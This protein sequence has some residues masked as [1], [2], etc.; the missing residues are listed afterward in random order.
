MFFICL[1][2]S[3]ARLEL[4]L[5]ILSFLFLSSYAQYT[6]SLET[7]DSS[8][9]LKILQAQF[10]VLDSVH[11]TVQASARLNANKQISK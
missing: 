11:S 1:H 2:L 4:M 3:Y 9:G 6:I 10:Y 7:L 5:T 8:F